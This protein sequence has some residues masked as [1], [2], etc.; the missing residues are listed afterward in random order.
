MP[1]KTLCKVDRD[2]LLLVR[3]AG[4]SGTNPSPLFFRSIPWI[5]KGLG[6]IGGSFDR[7]GPIMK[8]NRSTEGMRQR[9]GHLKCPASTLRCLRRRSGGK[10]KE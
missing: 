3:V 6:L 2:S 10:L 9:A 7:N 8:N 5:G 1:A 4:K